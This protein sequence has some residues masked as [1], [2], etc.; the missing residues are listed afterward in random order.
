[1]VIAIYNNEIM[2]LN[3]II[4]YI[5]WS[6]KPFLQKKYN[7]FYS[8]LEECDQSG[9]YKDA[10]SHKENRKNDVLITSVVVYITL[11]TNQ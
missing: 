9:L 10:A 1:M 7:I 2:H 6:F 4:K 8:H 5:S 11:E 3:N